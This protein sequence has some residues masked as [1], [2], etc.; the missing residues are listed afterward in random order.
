MQIGDTYTSKVET[1][2]VAQVDVDMPPKK[3][4]QVQ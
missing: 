4:F 2:V 3:L 1:S